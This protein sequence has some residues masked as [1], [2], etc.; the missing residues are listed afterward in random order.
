MNLQNPG[1]VIIVTTKL[2]DISSFKEVSPTDEILE[3][4]F[5]LTPTDSPGVRFECMGVEDASVTLYLGITF[6]IMIFIGLF[7]LAYSLA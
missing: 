6:I 3:G 7:Y 5:D 4:L 1:N 2:S